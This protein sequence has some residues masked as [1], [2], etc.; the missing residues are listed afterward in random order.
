M[1]C[2]VS[3]ETECSVSGFSVELH[4]SLDCNLLAPDLVTLLAMTLEDPKVLPVVSTDLERRWSDS[5]EE[6]GGV[7]LLFLS[8]RVVVETPSGLN[9]VVPTHTLGVGPVLTSNCA[10]ND[11]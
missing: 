2:E 5:L 3:S 8:C 4:S 7:G 11:E 9:F 6:S 10:G 1:V